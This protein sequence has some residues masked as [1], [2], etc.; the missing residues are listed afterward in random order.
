M[1]QVQAGSSNATITVKFYDA[2][3]A[4]ETPA[5]A[6]YTTQG[7]EDEGDAWTE[8]RSATAISPLAS[9]STIEL[10]A[11]DTG[12]IGAGP[13]EERRICVYVDSSFYESFTFEVVAPVCS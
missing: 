1:Q 13:V 6:T 5:T 12:L 11:T 8:L 4:L 2:D 3:G 9:T 10:D 7:R